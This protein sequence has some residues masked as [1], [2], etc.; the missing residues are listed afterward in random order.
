VS[1]EIN[2]RFAGQYFDAETGLHYNYHRYYDPATGRYL[3]PDPIGLEGGINPYAYS[4]N[5]PINYVDPYGLMNTATWGQVGGGLLVTPV[6]G[7]R[8]LGGAVL[9]GAVGYAAW[10]T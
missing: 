5:N 8:I 3:T 4:E 9:A 2:L 1:V 10:Q 6:P 7:A